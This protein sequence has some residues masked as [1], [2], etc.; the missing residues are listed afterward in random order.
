MILVH[1]LLLGFQLIQQAA[2]SSSRLML[3]GTSEL[4]PLKFRHLRSYL[5]FS[6][7]Q[8]RL[9]LICY[10]RV[11][12]QKSLLLTYLIKIFWHG[13]IPVGKIT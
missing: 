9:S 11:R 4:I 6:A 8:P 13:S 7:Q 12:M 3:L 10:T 1:L 2:F 5:E